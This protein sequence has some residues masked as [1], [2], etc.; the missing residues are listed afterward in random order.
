MFGPPQKMDLLN[1]G[2][3]RTI[4]FLIPTH[5]RPAFG[6]VVAALPP[7][8]LHFPA[9]AETFEYKVSCN[10]RL[11][12]FALVIGKSNQD[13]APKVEFLCIH[14]G[15]AGRNDCELEEE[16][17]EGLQRHSLFL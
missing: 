11:Q 8:F 14:H 15:E 5:Q 3:D 13:R 1:G 16:S 9:T 4:H 10:A 2:Y 7:A 6:H 17:T 12:L